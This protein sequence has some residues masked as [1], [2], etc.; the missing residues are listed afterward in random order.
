MVL[1]VALID[2]R[3]GTEDEFEAAYRQVRHAVAEAG[4]A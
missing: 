4:V 1:E 2:V 3:P